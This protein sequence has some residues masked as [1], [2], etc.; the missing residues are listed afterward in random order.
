VLV[1]AHALDMNDPFIG[2]ENR[3]ASSPNRMRTR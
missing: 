1:D 3:S 2:A